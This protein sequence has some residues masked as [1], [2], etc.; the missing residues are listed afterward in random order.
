MRKNVR[1]CL[2][3]AVYTSVHGLHGVWG[4]QGGQP[5][6]QAISTQEIFLGRGQ[7]LRFR[8]YT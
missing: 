8:V 4:V 5:T 7:G 6:L 1:E 3:D 2:Q